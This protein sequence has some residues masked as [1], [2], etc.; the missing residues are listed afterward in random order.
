MSSSRA[1]DVP[2]DARRRHVSAQDVL[3]VVAV[4][5]G[6]ALA[7]YVLYEVRRV[8]VWLFVAAFFAAVIAPLVTWVE[9]RGVRRGLA[10]AI[11][12]IGL[13]LAIGALLF[14][15]AKPIVT[16]AVDFA[17]N[18]P[19]NIDRLKRLPL[20]RDVVQRFNLQGNVNSVSSD[21]PHQLVGFSGPLLSAFA[22]VG[23]AIV[24]FVSIVVLT[25]FFL[26][27]GPE[28]VALVE[29]SIAS[30]HHRDRITVIGRRSLQA[31]SGWVAGNV[32]TSIVAAVAS[33]IV[34]AILGL[35][36]SFLLGLWVGVADLIPLVGATLGAIPAVIV[37]F[38]HSLTAGIVVIVFFIVYQ[39][40]ENHVLQPVVYG[41]TIRL[42]PFLVLLAVLLGVELAGFL[43]A[44]LALPIAGVLQVTFEELA[45]RG[46]TLGSADDDEDGAT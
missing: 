31:V 41:R 13:T 4:L 11:V 5:L 45:P 3:I 37:A 39:Q 6:V 15:F 20:I 43:G 24:G 30:R 40:V 7:L 14:A 42:N 26:L 21:L 29:R 19:E 34:F 23:E 32:L 1:P 36:Y 12:V 38:L 16:Q 33:L 46:L 25:I 18:L 44:L 35:P 2:R 27:Y 28:I 22:S 10:V 8:L 9:R 17:T